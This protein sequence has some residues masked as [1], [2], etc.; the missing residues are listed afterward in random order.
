[1]SDILQRIDNGILTLTFNR[2][3]KKNSITTEMYSILATALRDAAT[4]P[5]I[6]IVII[7]GQEDVFTAG[8]DLADFLQNPADSKDAPAWEFMLSLVEFPKPLI[9]AVSGAAIGIGTTLLLH[10][11]LVYAS[12]TAKFM[13][14]F[15]NLGLC[16]EAAS[17]FILPR[18]IG[19]QKAAKLLMFG[20]TFS[21][22]E[23]LDLGIINEI[24]NANEVN[25]YA[26]TQAKHLLERPITSLMATKKLMKSAL[27][28][29]LKET[30]NQER[31][32]FVE[33]LKGPAL[34]EAVAAFSE[35]RKPR[36]S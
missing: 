14:P 23:A 34:K 29:E 12:N 11:D 17:S 13:L 2:P 8:N 26:L 22:E 6:K 19:H 24:V 27:M 15:V 33:L 4:K 9:A 18:L 5:M 7:N 10:C 20:D 36:F 35:K 31:D 16:P 28:N 30:I 21:S 1:M 32:E 3:S 25:E